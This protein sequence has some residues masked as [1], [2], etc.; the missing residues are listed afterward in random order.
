MKKL[1]R[2]LILTRETIKGLVDVRE[3]VAA[4]E[5]A[6]KL[7]GKGKVEMPPKVYLRLDRY[8]GDF[9]AMPAFIEKLGCCA[10][11]WV[12]V[13]PRNRM[14]GLPTVMAIIILSDPRNGFPLCI[15]D[16]TYAT[17]LRTGAAGGVAA[18]YLARKDSERI[19]L[20]GCGAQGRAQ[21]RALDVLF[22][23]EQVNIWGHEGSYVEEF[24]RNMK[25]LKLNL[26]VSRSIQDCVKDCDI[27]V[28]T[29]P[30]RRP[31]VKLKWLKKGAHINAIGADAEGKQELE[32]AILKRAKVVVDGWEQASHG[33]EINVALKKGLISRRDIYAT[34]GQIVA[35]KK[36]GRATH[37]EMTV[38]DSTGLAIQDVAIANL[39]YK[40]ALENKAGKY[41]KLI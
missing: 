1:Y 3:S 38:F 21:L 37:D 23:I 27:V 22:D 5:E 20:V 9:R 36:E 40:K 34:I 25:G 17:D 13:H 26:R 2:T 15:M 32:S 11:K 12:N 4:I 30:S 39:V 14:I 18:K 31:L 24:I 33:G 41:L 19:G 29:T 35:G 28:T 6:F 10:M 8:H 16:G 7:Y